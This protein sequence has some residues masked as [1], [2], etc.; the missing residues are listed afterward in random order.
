MQS[1]VFITGGTG[2]VG[3]DII[4][5][6]LRDDSV[7]RVIALVRG[8]KQTALPRLVDS[9]QKLESAPLEVRMLEKLTVVCGDVTQAHF[10]W[11]QQ[12]WLA[13]ARRVT[14]IIH[15]AADVRFHL[16]LEDARRVNVGGTRIMLAFAEQAADAG[17]LRHFAYISTA[18]VCGDRGGVILEEGDVCLPRFTNSYE[19]S[20]W[21]CEQLVREAFADLPAT[22]FRPSIIVGDARTGRTNAFKA[23]YMPLRFI[24]RNLLGGVVPPGDA[25]LDVVPVDYVSRAVCHVL[26]SCKGAGH[27]LHL[28]AGAARSSSAAEIAVRARLAAGLPGVPDPLPQNASARRD[29][30]GAQVLASFAPYM[31]CRRDFD[32]TNTRAAL[33][34]SGITVPAFRNYLDV[35]IG[36]CLETGW[37]KRLPQ[38]A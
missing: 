26:L 5:R 30:A 13:C 21:E 12:D 32:D 20:K 29:S 28:T 35:I 18:Y 27:T 36:F 10:G 24:A 4:R 8:S 1:T 37:G 19:Q 11:P 25:P 2:L 16:P 7:E 9:V 14:H 3:A 15:S 6:L 33:A 38:A 31:T 22:I 17:S 23:L 34:G